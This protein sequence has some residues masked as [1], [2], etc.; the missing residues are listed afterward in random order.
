MNDERFVD[1][2]ELVLFCRGEQAKRYIAEAVACYRAGAFRSC[3]VATWIA[4]V[5]DFVEKLNQLELA[6]D[7]NAKKRRGEFERYREHGDV[8]GSL[9]FERQVPAMAREEFELISDL[10]RS[11][12]ERLLEDRNRCAHPSMNAAEELYA[13]PAELARTHLRNAVM[14]LLRHAPV[15]GKAALDRVLAEVQSVYFPTAIADVCVHLARGPLGN[16]RESLVRN[17]VVVL[18]KTLLRDGL[19]DQQLRRHAAALNGTRRL[20]PGGSERVMHEWLSKLIRELRDEDLPRVVTVLS[21]VPDSWVCC[22]DDVR[23]KINRV[24]EQLP[25]QMVAQCVPLA[26]DMAPLNACALRRLEY[27]TPGELCALVDVSPR[28]EYVTRAIDFY[29]KA[30]DE[31]AANM[32]GARL[33]VPLAPFLADADVERTFT[34]IASNPV[35]RAGSILGAVLR[36]IRDAGRVGVERFRALVVGAGLDVDYDWLLVASGPA[37]ERG[38]E[39]TSQ[40]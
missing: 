19:D 29:G 23:I 37:E 15:Q 26:L 8:K 1:L 40:V 4:I 39:D 5:F 24:V 30:E 13:P 38:T 33:I 17:V 16:P 9:L 2:D 10:E 31:G 14:H 27:T 32:Y 6:G 20:H 36:S 25:E 7:A 18:L 21:H 34:Y 28:Q 11:D 3:I 35:I 22:E 12:L